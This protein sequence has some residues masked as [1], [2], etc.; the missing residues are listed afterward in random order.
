[1]KKTIC[2]TSFWYGIINKLNLQVIE[3]A[4][5]FQVLREPIRNHK[6]QFWS[7]EWPREINEHNS[8]YDISY[9]YATQI[10]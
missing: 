7:S 6:F 3:I 5:K 4:N 2:S 10:T 1:M 8:F 9:V